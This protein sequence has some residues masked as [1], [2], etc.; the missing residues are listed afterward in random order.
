M[1]HIDDNTEPLFIALFKSSSFTLLLIFA[2]H[3]QGS[4]R[5]LLL[6]YMFQMKPQDTADP[7]RQVGQWTGRLLRVSALCLRLLDVVIYGHL[8]DVRTLRTGQGCGARD[9]DD[10]MFG[11]RT[12]R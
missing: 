5:V 4:P 12:W 9:L 2:S 6:W 8:M 1:K 7:G 10:Y 3:V 11:P